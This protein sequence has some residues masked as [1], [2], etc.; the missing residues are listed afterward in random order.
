ML[1]FDVAACDV[2]GRPVSTP[3]GKQ[4]FREFVEAAAR[5]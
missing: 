3:R 4:T 5:G 2:A 1:G